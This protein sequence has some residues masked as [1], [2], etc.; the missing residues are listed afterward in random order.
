MKILPVSMQCVSFCQNLE[1][2][3]SIEPFNVS[4]YNLENL[5]QSLLK[6]R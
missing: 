4:C 6:G 3:P 5:D 1:T 2:K